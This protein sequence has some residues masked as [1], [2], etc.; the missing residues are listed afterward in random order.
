[1]RK[2]NR[3]SGSAKELARAW[4]GLRKGKEHNLKSAPLRTKRSGG[5]RK[6]G[7]GKARQSLNIGA[8]S[9]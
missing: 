6:E 4:F 1:M 8:L 5:G 2:K 9:G 3:V 7:R